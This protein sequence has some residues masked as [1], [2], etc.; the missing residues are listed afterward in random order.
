M[1]DIRFIRDNLERLRHAARAKNTPCDLERLCAVD[2]QRRRIQQQLDQLRHQSKQLGAQMAL[3]RNPKSPWYKRSLAAGADPATIQAEAEKL[4]EQLEQIK[5]S[6]KSLQQQ[7]RGVLDEFNR[8][9]LTVPQPPAPDV[10]E[11]TDE[12]D[13]V[14]V[15]RVGQPPEFGFEPKDHI[16]LGLNLGIIDVDRGVKLAGTRNYILRAEGALLHQAVLKFG[17]DLMLQRGFVPL[18]VPIINRGSAFVGTGWFPEGREQV[19][20]I[21]RDELFLVG[22]AEV[23]VTSY[24]MDEI[25]DEHELPKR[26]VAQSLCFRREAGAAGKD[27][28]GLYRVHQFEK[29]EQVIICRNDEQASIEHHHEIVAN[30]EQLMQQLELPYRVVNVCTGDL[31]TGAVQRFDIEAWMPSRGGY[32]ETHSASRFYEFQARR[33]NLR[34]RDR[35]RR[36]HYCHTLNN[37]VVASP[38]ILIPLLE[39]NQRPDGSVTIPKALRP[40]MGGLECIR[41]RRSE[42]SHA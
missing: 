1:L 13:N 20:E 8:L 16:Q 28:Y 32:G 38:R 35:A 19:Y 18:T 39:I 3:Y 30:A 41:P 25:L 9:M 40:Y 15:R 31:S 22:T 23:P 17:Y 4:Q 42:A 11:G 29:V 7:Q 26:Y 12:R 33:L 10:P 37:T 21:P 36:L 27:T 6:I 5:T 34:Y 24:H 14:E 2:D